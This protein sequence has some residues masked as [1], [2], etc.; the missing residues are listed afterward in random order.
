[1]STRKIG[2]MRD[3]TFVRFGKLGTHVCHDQVPF[4][5]RTGALAW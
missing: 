3:G 5:T 2:R 1:M 4:M